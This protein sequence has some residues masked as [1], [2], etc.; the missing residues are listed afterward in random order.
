MSLYDVSCSVNKWRKYIL[1]M[2]PQFYIYI[3]NDIFH[4]SLY[5]EFILGKTSKNM[6]LPFN[7]FEIS[8]D[9]PSDIFPRNKGNSLHDKTSNMQ[10]K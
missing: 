2:L 10:D 4:F 9:S 3:Y 5:G 6:N 7:T 8:W 1:E